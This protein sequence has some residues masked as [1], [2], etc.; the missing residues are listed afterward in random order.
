MYRYRITL[1][2]KA[3]TSL[4]LCLMGG[5]E[6]AIADLPSVYQQAHHHYDSQ[7]QIIGMKINASDGIVGATDWH[8]DLFGNT[9]EKS[10]TLVSK[11]NQPNGLL[12]SGQVYHGEQSVYNA[13]NQLIK[14]INQQ[15][16]VQTYDYNANGQLN[17]IT[18]FAG[19][20]FTYQYNVMGQITHEAG[21]SQDGGQH[22]IRDSTY[23]SQTGQ[24]IKVQ[25]HW[26]APHEQTSVAEYT[27]YPDGKLE[28]T[29]QHNGNQVYQIDYRYDRYHRLISQT[30]GLGYTTLYTYDALNRIKHICLADKGHCTNDQITYHYI[31]TPADPHLGQVR[32]IDYPNGLIK[33]MTYDGLNHLATL[34][35]MDGTKNQQLRHI[36]YHYDQLGNL[37]SQ[38]IR[39]ETDTSFSANYDQHYQYNSLNQLTHSWITRPDDE[40]HIYQDTQTAF[41]ERDNLIRQTVIPGPNQATIQRDYR[42]NLLNQL[43]HITIRQGGN[44][45][46]DIALSD[47]W[48][49]N[50]NL[51]NDGQGNHF[52]YNILGQLTR[53]DNDQDPNHAIHAIYTYNVQ[54]LRDSK[55][56]NVD[57]QSQ[58][59][60]HYD[61]DNATNA[62]IINET[63]GAHQTHYL[64]NGNEHVVRFYDAT[65]SYLV[66]STKDI[67]AQIDSNNQVTKAYHYQPYGSPLKLDQLLQLNASNVLQPHQDQTADYSIQ[68]NPFQYS[69]EYTDAE[70]GMQYLRARYYA[71]WLHSFPQRDSKD[72][73]NR[74]AY[75]DGNPIM[76]TDPSG[77]FVLMAALA[78]FAVESLVNLVIT[79]TIDLMRGASWKEF[80]IDFAIGEGASLLPAGYAGYKAGQVGVEIGR[81]AQ[82]GLADLSSEDLLNNGAK[83]GQASEA[84]AQVAQDAVS[85]E[86]HEGSSIAEVAQE[87][88]IMANQVE[89]EAI[90]PEYANSNLE[91]YDSNTGYLD[92]GKELYVPDLGVFKNIEPQYEYQANI[93]QEGGM[94]WD[95]VQ[96]PYDVIDV[97]TEKTDFKDLIPK[98]DRFTQRFLDDIKQFRR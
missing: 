79:G 32:Q 13:D 43:T 54:G 53:Y 98:L 86:A 90:K 42:Y 83:L 58:T 2:K 52:D 78:T 65:P 47:N 87:D 55:Q 51:T 89:K 85:L 56:I 23:D 18:D 63:Q 82:A 49:K 1:K 21:Q 6:V 34:T 96:D 48:T 25:Q 41:D 35:M 24:L 97:G 50:G 76:N 71:P 93:I 17:K 30:D 36:H 26:I 22:Y 39:S 40:A 45:I 61:Y 64:M 29:K 81:A 57:G 95:M 77:H 92:S 27:Y 75:G 46:K 3:I 69:A 4:I 16:Q 68:A 74:Y 80:G 62:N 33:T 84:E 15:G 67:I 94:N 38:S 37:V 44:V 11:G 20:T 73:L 5:Q 72:L 91:Y 10:L 70:S 8:K 59:P 60:I 12:S 14:K 31:Q 66:K 88:D 7:G 9:V 28:Q 19:N